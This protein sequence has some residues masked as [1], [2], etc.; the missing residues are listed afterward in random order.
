M[1]ENQIKANRE[2]SFHECTRDYLFTC[3]WI[4]NQLVVLCDGRVVCGCADPYGE[5]PVGDLETQSL[6]EIWN[7]PLVHQIRRDLNE[8]H[9]C[10]CDP[11]GLKQ[12]LP[13]GAET[14]GRPVF[15]ERIPRIFFE[16]TVQCNLSCYRSVCNRESGILKTRRRTRFPLE[17]FCQ[18]MDE[19]APELVRL[20]FFNYGDPFVHPQAVDMIEYVK[21]R[22][23]HVYVYTSTNGLMLDEEKMLR[24]VQAGIDEITFSVDGPDQETYEKYRCGG[25][26]SRLI[27]IMKR[28]VLLRNQRDR[29]VPYI[30]WRYILF[31]WNDSRAQMKRTRQLAA[32]VGVDRLTWETTDHPPDAFSR[33]FLPGSPAWKK[34]RSEIWDTSQIGNALS[35]KNHRASIQPP[36]GVL[37]TE[38]GVELELSVMVKNTGGAIWRKD[39]VSGRRMVRLGAQLYAEDGTLINRD[40][41]RA[42]LNRSLRSGESDRLLLK[43][44]L[45]EHPG[46]YR[47]CFD[48]V[49]EGI[50][51]F[52]SGGSPTVWRKLKI[53]N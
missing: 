12:R 41:A 37:A 16:P 6:K 40:F 52:S 5:R 53:L 18:L 11:C 44:P 13:S 36:R 15:L 10:F 51:W 48:M 23:P 42:F 50:D 22:Y 34:I 46:Q 49:S 25:D 14:P 1:S 7:S 2:I 27:G 20:D 26:F 38:K 4:F 28:F 39:E 24:L 29:E 45:L 9:C 17:N 32:E 30:N 3:D 43:L 19:V 31:R 8:G 33:R 35:G 21:N 47:L